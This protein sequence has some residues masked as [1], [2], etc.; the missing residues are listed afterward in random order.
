MWW[1]CLRR[2][3]AYRCV[4]GDGKLVEIEVANQAAEA[5]H[6]K[7]G[8]YPPQA[9]FADTDGDGFGAGTATEGRTQP[10]GFVATGGDGAP[11]DGTISPG[12]TEACG[13]KKGEGL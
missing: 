9:C 3:G 7:H 6:R 4:R 10:A 1:G 5:G 2:P 13:E 8:D 12:A 11:T